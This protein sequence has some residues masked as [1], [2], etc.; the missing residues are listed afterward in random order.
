MRGLT[1]SAKGVPTG[2]FLAVPLFHLGCRASRGS[3]ESRARI[4]SHQPLGRATASR[5]LAAEVSPRLESFLTVFDELIPSDSYSPT[6]ESSAPLRRPCVNRAALCSTARIGV[7]TRARRSACRSGEP[8]S[9][10]AVR[11]LEDEE[12]YAKK[13]KVTVKNSFDVE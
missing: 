7:Q 2:H 11:L 10:S 12:E 3:R 5:W 9:V 1:A 4:H 6:P 13:T 8:L